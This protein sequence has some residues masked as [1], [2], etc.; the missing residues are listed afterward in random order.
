MLPLLALDGTGTAALLVLARSRRSR[1]AESLTAESLTAR[2][3]LAGWCCALLAG[4]LLAVRPGSAAARLARALVVGG[5]ILTVGGSVAAWRRR[6]SR[7]PTLVP[8]LGA[9]AGAL[10]V[11]A[12]LAALRSSE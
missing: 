8:T 3:A 1:S 7:M 11:P 9:F 4:A 6:A 12:Y 5:G 2:A 10:L